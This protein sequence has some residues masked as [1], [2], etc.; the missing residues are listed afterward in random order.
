M[1]QLER[2]DRKLLV[3]TM[4]QLKRQTPGLSDEHARDRAIELI[5]CTEAVFR[6]LSEQELTR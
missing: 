4:L 3:E 2:M 5:Q 1:L 6:P